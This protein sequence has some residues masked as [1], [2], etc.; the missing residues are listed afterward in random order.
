MFQPLALA[1]K[2]EEKLGC[3]ATASPRPT[4]FQIT[5]SFAAFLWQM[6]PIVPVL[7][8]H[9]ANKPFAVNKVP[10]LRYLDTV[11]VKSSNLLLPTTSSPTYGQCGLGVTLRRLAHNW[12]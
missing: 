2:R 12:G 9:P 5:E 7:P 11:E 8:T 4:W 1:E 6:A 10:A 3:S